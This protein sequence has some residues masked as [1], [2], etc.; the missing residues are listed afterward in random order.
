M[1]KGYATW[2][3]LAVLVTFVFAHGVRANFV[4]GEI[5]DEEDVLAS[6]FDVS[7]YY[8]EAPEFYTSCKVSPEENKY[9]CDPNGIDDV[10]WEIGKEVGARVFE[11]G[12]VAGPV[13][14]VISGE[15]YDVFPEMQLKK[16][17]KVHQPN[18]SVYLKAEEIFVNVS[19]IEEYGNLRYVLKLYG[20][21]VQ[22]GEICTGCTHG[23]F[24][25]ED[26]KF[27][28]YELEVIAW[29]DEEE[30]VLESKIFSLLEYINFGRNIECERCRKNY[31][32][33]GSVVNMTVIMETSH[34]VSGVL[35]DHFPADWV[36]LETE[37]FESG[38]VSE[39][40]STHNS[41]SWDIEG[42]SAKRTYKLKAPKVLFPR[43]YFFQLDFDSYLGELDEVIVYRFFR[44]FSF[45]KKYLRELPEMNYFSK[46]SMIS[47]A[48][49][50]VMNLE[51][52]DLDLVALFP[53]RTLE[54]VHAFVHKKS[55]VRMRKT[56]K[57]FVI[58]SNVDDSDIGRIL[59][60]F[61][62]EKPST[63]KRI[64]SVGLFWYDVVED[65]WQ[66][67]E[68]LQYAEDE[69]HFYYEANAEA[70][71]AFAIKVETERIR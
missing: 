9:C 40:S 58:G 22:E 19:V 1:K 30:E 14:L 21:V 3:L 62:V 20:N 65:S 46:Y 23:E 24:Y 18:S 49:A 29:N 54:D 44:F 43:R 57:H 2:I 27:G 67:L 55:P 37:S 47:P 48:N 16:V 8:T 63:K 31:V 35:T 69:E 11:R 25:L 4:C 71:G 50:L 39:M 15:G 56:N 70:K 38:S 64:K 42:S 53:T 34:R 26:L 59:I 7:V 28:Q 13:S 17:I 51:D 60:R 41:I 52:E 10:N 45:P 32:Y 12:Y 5:R 61:K 68:S 66:E 33:S 6:W 36:Y